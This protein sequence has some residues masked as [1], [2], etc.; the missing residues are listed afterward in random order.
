MLQ[1]DYFVMVEVNQFKARLYFYRPNF[2]TIICMI[3]RVKRHQYRRKV[4]RNNFL[5]DWPWLSE[6]ASVI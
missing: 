4:D 3:L 6:Q 2:E 5:V 1:T